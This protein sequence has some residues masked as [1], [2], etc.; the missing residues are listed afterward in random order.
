[1]KIIVFHAHVGCETGC[2]GHVIQQEGDKEFFEYEHPYN[3]SNL[4]FAQRMVRETY[5]EEHVKDL[6]WDNSIVS[7]D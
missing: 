6:D 1:M 7:D 4:E 2:C 5:G 3:E